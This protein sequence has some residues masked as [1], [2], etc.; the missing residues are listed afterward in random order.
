MFLVL[1]FAYSYNEYDENK[2]HILNIFDIWILSSYN[3][4]IHI[5]NIYCTFITKN[6]PNTQGQNV[7]VTKGGANIW[8]KCPSLKLTKPR[9]K[10]DDK[11]L[12]RQKPEEWAACFAP[13]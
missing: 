1:N 4:Y 12:F 13:I 3:E 7:F 9:N 11:A 8:N 6:I 2:I 5:T 10:G